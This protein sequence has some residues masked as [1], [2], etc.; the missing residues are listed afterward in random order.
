MTGNRPVDLNCS[1]NNIFWVWGVKITFYNLCGHQSTLR[2][3]GANELPAPLPAGV[4][5]LLGVD[6]NILSSG[7]VI[8]NLPDGAGIELDYPLLSIDQLAVLYWDDPD[9]DGQGEWVEVSQP[10]SRSQLTQ[11]LTTKSEDELYKLKTLTDGGFYP[12]LTTDRTGIFILVA[13]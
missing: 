10:L 6:V 3:I 9:G 12:V 2:G 4:S 13:K 8:K 11:A 7:Q 1:S 5:Y